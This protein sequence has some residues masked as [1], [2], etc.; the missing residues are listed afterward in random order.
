M[1]DIHMR[2]YD[3]DDDLVRSLCGKLT[4]NWT[5]DVQAVTCPNCVGIMDLQPA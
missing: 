3:Y 2:R 4:V 5:S 1:R